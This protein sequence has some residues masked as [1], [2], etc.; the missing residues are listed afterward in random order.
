MK[1][2]AARVWLPYLSVVFLGGALL[3]PWVHFLVVQLVKLGWIPG[4]LAQI[5]FHRYVH[6]CL[7]LM[8]VVFL[9]PALR[10]L[11]V[12]S[13]AKVGVV[14]RREAVSRWAEGFCLGF[15]CFACIAGAN[16][17]AGSRRLNLDS[18]WMEV[19]GHL[20]NAGSSALVVSFLE[21]LLFR[22]GL[23]GTL[24]RSTSV[25]VASV[26]SSFVYALVHF[27]APFRLEG[28]VHWNS[29]LIVLGGMLR[30][31][32]QLES[33]FP[34]FLTLAAAGMILALAYER[35]GSLWIST[36]IHAGWVLWLKSFAFFTVEGSLAN[37]KLWGSS[38]LIDG[39]L[40]FVVLVPFVLWLHWRGTSQ[41][42]HSKALSWY[43]QAS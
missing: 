31:F 1:K 7:L 5:P 14:W 16:L 33:W 35:A 12:R 36:G 21:E 34:S 38:K 13:W 4:G 3:A 23:F 39:W 41:T 17:L 26:C 22:G 20:A 19:F 18:P 2:H 9:W 28:E 8:A 32:A 10:R 30:G 40:S 29:G 15:S 37:P 25:A 24:R 42:K 6:R 11:E 43:R 27:F